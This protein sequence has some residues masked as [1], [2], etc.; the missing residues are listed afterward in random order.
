MWWSPHLQVTQAVTFPESDLENLQVGD[1]GSQTSQTLFP[2]ST[3]SHQQSIP[4]R[5]LQ[6]PVYPAA[7]VG[8]QRSDGEKKKKKKKEEE[9]ENQSQESTEDKEEVIF[10]SSTGFLLSYNVLLL[11]PQ[12]FHW[13]SSHV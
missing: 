3:H 7:N 10:S 2:T 13:V 6:D 9:E 5:R 1:E 11:V 8:V 4:T 12:R